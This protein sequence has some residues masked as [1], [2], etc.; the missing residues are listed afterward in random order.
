V[1]VHHED[2]DSE[3]EATDTD[4]DT[5]DKVQRVATNVRGSQLKAVTSY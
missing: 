2:V 1:A 5:H 3:V 4:D